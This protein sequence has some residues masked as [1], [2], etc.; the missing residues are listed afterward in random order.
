RLQAAAGPAVRD[1]VTFAVEHPAADLSG[2]AL[3]R[4]LGR[5]PR[6]L[7][8]VLRRETGRSPPRVHEQG[9]PAAAP[10]RPPPPP[11]APARRPAP[12]GFGSAEVMRRAFVRLCGMTPTDYR[13][14]FGAAS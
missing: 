9:P 7:S 14:R 6:Q 5:S 12:A 3:A 10:R 11:P 1:L 2:P 13:A 4:R 8:R